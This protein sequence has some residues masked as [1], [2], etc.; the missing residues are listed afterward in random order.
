M[1]ERFLILLIQEQLKCSARISYACTETSFRFIIVWL[2]RVT[3]ISNLV[4][5]QTHRR[6]NFRSANNIY[7]GL[8]DFS[9][10]RQQPFLAVS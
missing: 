6:V 4:R 8:I 3:S 9:A 2:L 5:I 7:W 1:D 10:T